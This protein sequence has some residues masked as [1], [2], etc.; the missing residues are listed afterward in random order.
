MSHSFH[1][2]NVFREDVVHESLTN[3]DALANAPEAEDG[4][5]KVPAVLQDTGGA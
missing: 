5:F 4:C 2:E 3:E 1:L